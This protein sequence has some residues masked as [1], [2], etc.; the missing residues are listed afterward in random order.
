MGQ[1]IRIETHDYVIELQSVTRR[2]KTD[3]QVWR[4]GQPNKGRS[5]KVSGKQKD[6]LVN[7]INKKGHTLLRSESGGNFLV[8]GRTWKIDED[9]VSKYAVQR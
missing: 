2:G 6:N 1:I 5:R 4:V 7:T 9:I 8:Y 3:E